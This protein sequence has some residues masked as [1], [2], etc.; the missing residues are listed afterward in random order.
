MKPSWHVLQKLQETPPPL[1]S[2]VNAFSNFKNCKSF[3]SIHESWNKKQKKPFHNPF[4][5]WCWI[6]PFLSN[7]RKRTFILFDKSV[8]QELLQ[9]THLENVNGLL[10]SSIWM[11]YLKWRTSWLC[12]GSYGIKNKT[13][14]N[15][16]FAH[17]V[18][19][20]LVSWLKWY[21]MKV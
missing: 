20:T 21:L 12:K 13:R 6:N 17:F 3:N 11:L 9:L 10:Y 14:K 4:N 16:H 2:T 5:C 7:H 15:F 1:N 8:E 19:I 18:W